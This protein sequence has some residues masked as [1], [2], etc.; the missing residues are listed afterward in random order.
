M[1]TK[2][3][4]WGSIV[5]RSKCLNL[6][7]LQPDDAAGRTRNR[8]ADGLSAPSHYAAAFSSLSRAFVGRVSFHTGATANAF[9]RAHSLSI[10][11]TGLVSGRRRDNEHDG[12]SE[13]CYRR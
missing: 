7:M 10:N 1:T 3:L 11:L 2:N 9:Y 6:T 12:A 8:L 13:V 5:S 4:L